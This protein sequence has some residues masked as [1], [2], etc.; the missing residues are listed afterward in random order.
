VTKFINLKIKPTQS[1]RVTR[2]VSSVRVC[3]SD[4]LYYIFLKKP[5]PDR[6]TFPLPRCEVCTY[7]RDGHVHASR[8]GKKC[9][10]FLPRCPGPGG[11]IIP[12]WHRTSLPLIP[13]AAHPPT[14]YRR[15]HAPYISP[16]FYASCSRRRH[17]RLVRASPSFSDSGEPF[18]PAEDV[19]RSRGWV[20]GCSSAVDILVPVVPCW[21]R[22]S[23]GW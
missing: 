4:D 17:L 15:R 13:T 7:T 14:R 10:S 11:Q 22:G 21:I 16:L 12:R 8:E 9:D 1:F 20:V 18:T 19:W 2:R 23:E 5:S 3:I 6:R